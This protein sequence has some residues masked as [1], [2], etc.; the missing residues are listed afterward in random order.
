LLIETCNSWD[1][2]FFQR[3]I[4][5][6]MVIHKEIVTTFPESLID[7]EKF[8]SDTSPFKDDYDWQAF[9]ISKDSI[10][11]SKAILCWRKNEPVG[12]LGFLDW[13]NNEEAAKLLIN[14][15]CAEGRK[16]GLKKIKTP[17][18]LNLYVKYRIKLPGGGDPF[19]GEP[20]YPDYYHDL[21]HRCGFSEIARWD[22]Y[23]I[24]KWDGIKDYLL[25]RKKLGKKTQSVHNKSLDKN[26]RTS[27]R[28][29]EM[30]KWDEELKIIHQLFNEAYQS[31]PEWEPISFSQFKIIYDDFKY[32]INPLYAYIVELRGKPVGFSINFADP[33]LI[34]NKVR[35]KKLTKMDKALLLL[36]LRLN[37]STLLIAHVGKISGPDGEEVKGVQIQVSNRIQFI[38]SI[39]RKTLVT[40]QVKDSPS[41]RSFEEKTQKAFSQYVLYGMSLE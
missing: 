10:V 31:M 15:V 26:L 41:R 3:M 34:L 12:N 1:E 24:K 14:S 2:S 30:S 6:K 4:D 17:I 9:I 8:F 13:V 36:K 25:K 18:D 29:V 20:I 5:F 39:M 21:F 16:C 35:N 11:L 27:I 22:T 19:W 28:C 7:Y 38:V 40:F 33:L 23:E 32:I 37:R